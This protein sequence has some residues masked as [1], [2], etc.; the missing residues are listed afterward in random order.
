VIVEDRRLQSWRGRRFFG[1]QAANA[2]LRHRG[3]LQRPPHRTGMV[4]PRAHVLI[5]QIRVRVDLQDA[6]PGIFGSGRRNQRRRDRVFATQGDQELVAVQDLGGNPLNLA[7]QR[8]ELA[9][10]ELHRRQRE[11]ADRMDVDADFVV[12]QFHVRRCL[13]DLVRAIARAAD[14]RRG[15]VDGNRQHDHAGRV[16]RTRMGKRA[17]ESERNAMIVVEREGHGP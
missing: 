4:V 6:E 16:E 7:H 14:V 17:A 15:A 13:E 8:I 5:P 2:N 12:P 10:G 9:E 3:V 11:N 1:R